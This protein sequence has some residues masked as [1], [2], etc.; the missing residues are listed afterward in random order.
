MKDNQN[1]LPGFLLGIA[2]GAVVTIF[3]QGE[4]GQSIIRNAKSGI[5]DVTED[6]KN[7]I[8][9]IDDTLEKWVNKS[10]SIINELK[11]K[12]KTDIYD[13]DEIFS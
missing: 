8:E 11:G 1:F 6:L 10:R 9:N 3:L 4:R 2:A 7:G 13:L 12:K 5:K